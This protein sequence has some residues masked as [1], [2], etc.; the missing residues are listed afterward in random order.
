MWIKKFEDG[1]LKVWDPTRTESEPANL[2]QPFDP[3]T[4]EAWTNEDS[5]FAWA[6]EMIFA[7]ENP[8][9]VEIIEPEIVEEENA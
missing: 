7:A 1:A 8:P 4:G 5:A 9:I 2:F 6:D 3:N